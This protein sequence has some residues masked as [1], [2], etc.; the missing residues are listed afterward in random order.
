MKKY[1]KLKKV[2]KCIAAILGILFVLAAVFYINIKSFTVKRLQSPVGQDV[3]LM[4]TFHTD[5][6]GAV[7]NY[8][9]EEMLN[10]IQNI[11]PDVVFIEARED[12]R[13]MAR[14]LYTL[15]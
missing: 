4:G 1:S 10:A 11:N 7:S 9:V 8:S 15:T 6:F 13:A 2:F 5:H 3:Y 14:S 12:L